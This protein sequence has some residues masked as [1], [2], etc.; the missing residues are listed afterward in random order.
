M[1][2]QLGSLPTTLNSEA[3]SAPYT[4]IY[5]WQYDT[6]LSKP[7][8]LKVGSVHLPKPMLRFH[9][10]SLWYMHITDF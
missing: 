9:V 5:S 3:G 4:T 7:Y 6:L 8:L 2:D 10:Y 1:F